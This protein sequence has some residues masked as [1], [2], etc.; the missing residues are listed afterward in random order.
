MALSGWAR[1]KSGL[2]RITRKV[3]RWAGLAA[4]AWLVVLGATGIVLD[5]PEWRW[6]K[7]VTLTEAW[8]SQH[9]LQD[10]VRGIILR[11]FTINPDNG[12]Q[13]I[14]GGERGLWRSADG[15]AT[16]TP[17]AYDAYN[18]V[19][20]LLALV[21][22]PADPWHRLY[23]GTDDGIW[24]VD[25][26]EGPARRFALDGEVLTHLSEGASDDE[27]LGVI[28]N[29]TIVRLDKNEPERANWIDMKTASVTGLPPA[30]SLSRVLTD[31][32]FGNGI[33][34]GGLSVLVSDLAGAAI[35]LLC[36]T[37]LLQWLLPRRWR[38][39]A[40]G[41]TPQ[42]QT[43]MRWLFRAHA[44]LV[45]LVAIIPILYLS[46]S[47]IV[48]D[49]PGEIMDVTTPMEVPR[50]LLTAAYGPRNF[51]GEIKNVAIDSSNG[52]IAA[53]T[54]FGLIQSINGGSPWAFVADAPLSAHKKGG[55]ISI[56]RKQGAT[57]LGTHGGP[58]Y[59]RYDGSDE[60]TL[61]PN[62]RTL[63]LDGV[64]IGDEWTF[65][66]SRGFV[67]GTLDEGEWRR[68]EVSLPDISGMPVYNFLVDLH[69]GLMFHD[70]FIWLNDVVALAAIFLVLSGFINWLYR[71]WR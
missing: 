46:V 65:K 55:L 42:R 63:I 21:A 6:A 56:L 68:I 26:G 19:P 62:L 17:V 44:P 51:G 69:T 30:I 24:V 1:F 23:L 50:T 57:F 47:G 12:D 28:D 5:H 31:L 8:G 36:L 64:K 11:Q 40:S 13:M 70:Q 49:H 58:N 15:G 38:K 54:R 4:M 41:G 37:G 34:K 35:V 2:R 27:L 71:R 43:T 7:Q 60:W 48:F 53:M 45:G 39:R 33:F 20:R 9:V 52:R 22:E 67:R 32:H 61:I 29:T 3:H 10:E 16:W 59:V 66:G 18:G 14:A 25:G